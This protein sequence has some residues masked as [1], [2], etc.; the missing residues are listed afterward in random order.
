[1]V[2]VQQESKAQAAAWSIVED[3]VLI[4]FTHDVFHCNIDELVM[5]KVCMCK[6]VVDRRELGT[7]VSFF[8]STLPVVLQESVPIVAESHCKSCLSSVCLEVQVV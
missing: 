7:L 4:N 1:M 5:I 6:H 2:I 3:P 8:D